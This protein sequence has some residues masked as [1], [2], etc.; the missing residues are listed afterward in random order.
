VTIVEVKPASG[1]VAA[2]LKPGTSANTWI[3][4]LVPNS[5]D[6]PST[7]KLEIRTALGN[8]ISTY[9]VFAIIR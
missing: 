3:L 9:T 2:E 4:S 6:T 5:I 7:T 8:R 1:A